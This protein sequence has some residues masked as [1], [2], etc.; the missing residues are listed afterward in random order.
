MEKGPRQLS[1]VLT[2][3]WDAALA[4]P[5]LPKPLDRILQDL[6]G[7]VPGREERKKEGRK[8]GKK[9]PFPA[10]QLMAKRTEAP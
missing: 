10:C 2:L 4:L 3:I 1:Q 8:E 9:F 5:R 6:V 7:Q